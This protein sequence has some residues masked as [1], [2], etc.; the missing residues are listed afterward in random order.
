MI[1]IPCTRRSNGDRIAVS[2]CE[3][4]CGGCPDFDDFLTLQEMYINLFYD[5]R[6]CPICGGTGITESTYNCFL[7]GMNAP[8]RFILE[9]EQT[10]KNKK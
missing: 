7:C 6:V 10:K 4:V 8:W 2:V 3:K 1:Y 5:E 9:I